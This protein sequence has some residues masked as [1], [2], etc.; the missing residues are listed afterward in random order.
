MSQIAIRPAELD[1]MEGILEI[2]N[3]SILHTTANYNY[4]P[5]TLGDQQQWFTQ[6]CEKNFPVFVAESSGCILGFSTYGTFRE[7]TGYR[8]TVEHSVYVLDGNSGKGIGRQLL[9]ALIESAKQQGYHNMIGGIDA[10]NSESIAFHKKFGFVEC[11][12]IRQ[13]AFKFDRWLDLMFMQLILK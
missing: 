11:G 8:F 2:V 1:D 10:S 5:Q 7:R 6:K 4:D 3:H 13:A 12:V 9:S